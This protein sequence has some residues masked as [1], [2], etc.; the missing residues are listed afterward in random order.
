MD[1]GVG[2][3]RRCRVLMLLASPLTWDGRVRRSARSLARNGY[4]VTVACEPDDD[5]G[6]PAADDEEY[7]VVATP[8]PLAKAFERAQAAKR[9]LE[10]V[11]MELD[12]LEA[13]PAIEPGRLAKP[14]KELTRLKRHLSVARARARQSRAHVP[15][16]IYRRAWSGLVEEIRPDVIHC[17]DHHGLSTAYAACDRAKVIY[18]SHEFANGKDVNSD[19]NESLRAYL[20]RY[21]PAADAVVTVSP[22]LARALVTDLALSAPPLVLHNTPSMR[23]QRGPPYDLRT[24]IGLD[25]TTPLLVYTGGV[26]ARRRL[27]TPIGALRSLPGAHLAVIA[28]KHPREVAEMAASLGLADRV[29]FPPPAPYDRLV[30][31]IRTADVAVHPLDR[32]TNGDVALPNKLFEYLHADLPM[33]V[34]D[35]PQMAAFV[36]THRL[37]EVAPVDDSDAWAVALARVLAHPENYRGDPDDRSRLRREWSWETQEEA[38]LAL[39][40]RLTVGRD[41]ASDRAPVSGGIRGS[42]AR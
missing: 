5:A 30:S 28:V 31:L 15:E 2:T 19:S 17:H 40:E 21:A 18:D 3:S 10:R 23:D 42:G 1:R 12:R 38:L 4:D 39:Y 35:S 33:V 36:R 20:T 13:D 9:A 24:G 6:A 37:G 11:R 27:E 25:S 29:H 14:R 26:S 22:A 41:P 32:Y 34:S 7:R 16:G 8:I